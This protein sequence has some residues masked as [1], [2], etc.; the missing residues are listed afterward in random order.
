MS[1]LEFAPL[2]KLA[3]L[4]LLKTF[5]LYCKF[6]GRLQISA[7]LFSDTFV[8]PLESSEFFFPKF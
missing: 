6:F 5:I 4:E 1:Q 3:I 8:V 7:V 2:K